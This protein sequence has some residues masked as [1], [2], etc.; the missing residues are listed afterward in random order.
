[1]D[2]Y[3][4]NSNDTI[5]GYIQKNNYQNVFIKEDGVIKSYTPAQ[6]KSF[7]YFGGKGTENK[8]ISIPG[9]NRFFNVITEGRISLYADAVTDF[10]DR[11]V[12]TQYQILKD[13]KLIYF[14]SLSPRKRINELIS[15]CPSVYDDFNLHKKYKPRQIIEIVEAYNQCE[16]YK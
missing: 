13:N 14:K 5:Q 16:K 7:T 12:S 9:E 2:Y 8:F 6:I 4:N 11:S 3:I 15:D 10:Y 1:M